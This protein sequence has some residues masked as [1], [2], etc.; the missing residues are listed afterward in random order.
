M[1]RDQ[2]DEPPKILDC[3]LL[4]LLNS[5]LVQTFTAVGRLRRLKETK[6]W[7]NRDLGLDPGLNY[8]EYFK[9]HV[10]LC[11]QKFWL[12][13]QILV[14]IFNEFRGQRWDH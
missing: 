2:N 11:P 6:M 1:L 14:A 13:W 8:P 3:H 12:N 10:N 5:T 7:Q 4:T 9:W